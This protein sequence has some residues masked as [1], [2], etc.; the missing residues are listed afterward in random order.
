MASVSNA[1]TK[2]PAVETALRLALWQ[3][4][5]S[6]WLLMGLALGGTRSVVPRAFRQRA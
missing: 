2:A 6:V 5:Q 1:S 3:S 4:L